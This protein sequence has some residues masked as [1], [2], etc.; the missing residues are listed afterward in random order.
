MDTSYKL[1]D[2]FLNLDFQFKNLSRNNADEIIKFLERTLKEQHD[3]NISLSYDADSKAM[4]INYCQ[5]SSTPYTIQQAIKELRKVIS[6]K[7][8]KQ[9]DDLYKINE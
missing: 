5:S 9:A 4:Q 8:I 1:E 2:Q 7:N 3:F 6:E